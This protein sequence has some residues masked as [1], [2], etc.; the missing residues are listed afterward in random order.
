MNI[1]YL[2][3]NPTLCAKYHVDKHVVKMIL[4]YSQLLSTAHRKLDEHLSQSKN[5]IL[6]KSTHVNHPSSVWVRKSS[7][8][9]KWLLRLLK[10]LHKEY[11]FRYKKIHK[12][13]ELI[14]HLNIIPSNIEKRKCDP[15]PLAMPNDYKLDDP[16]LSYRNYYINGK[17]HL[18]S[19]KLRNTPTWFKC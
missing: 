1:F 5:D 2:D 3:K 17:S 9:Y 4:E 12:S 11:S 19:W 14:D 18:A 15:P 13:F 10:A 8:N 7:G 16:I 6:Y